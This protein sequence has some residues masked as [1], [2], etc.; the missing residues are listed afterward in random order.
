MG[1]RDVG[2]GYIEF[3]LAIDDIALV[4]SPHS[5]HGR[6]RDLVPGCIAPRAFREEELAVTTAGGHPRCVPSA[7]G[8]P[9]PAAVRPRPSLATP[10]PFAV[11]PDGAAVRL[12]R[13]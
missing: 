7:S 2:G 3:S 5:E 10:G 8:G 6:L 4:R 12:L 9:D 13:Y 11:N 1:R